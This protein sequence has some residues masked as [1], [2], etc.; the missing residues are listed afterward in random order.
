MT[1]TGPPE[2]ARES[3][4]EDGR[5]IAVT[6][7]VDI[8]SFA[9]VLSEVC[10]WVAFGKNGPHGLD[11]YRE[12][13]RTG[14]GRR[15]RGPDCF[16]LNDQILEAVEDE[17]T[18]IL[19]QQRCDVTTGGVLRLMPYMLHPEPKQRL[20]AVQ[21][22]RRLNDIVA[23]AQQHYASPSPS[24]PITPKSHA[25]ARPL[26]AEW[27]T[28]P[29]A[30]ILGH[31]RNR[32]PSKPG[33]TDGPEGSRSGENWA[34][35]PIVSTPQRM[36]S[37]IP[38]SD[39]YGHC[40][41][42]AEIANVLENRSI[43]SRDT[44]TM[45]R[46]ESKRR[47]TSDDEAPERHSSFAHRVASDGSA[48]YIGPQATPGRRKPNTSV[49]S[50]SRDALPGAS[51][52]RLS[53]TF[54][55]NSEEPA[56]VESPV[57]MSPVTGTI[58]QPAQKTTTQET[59]APPARINFASAERWRVKTKTEH[60]A[61]EPLPEIDCLDQLQGYDI[62][63]FVYIPNIRCT[64]DH[65]RYSSSTIQR[66]WARSGRLIIT[67]VATSPTSRIYLASCVTSPRPRM[68]MELICTTST[69]PPRGCGSA[70]SSL[71]Y[72]SRSPADRSEAP[73]LQQEPCET[74]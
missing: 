43:G 54:S 39:Q 65:C 51:S 52:A 36:T 56:Q 11:G 62:V 15:T 32:P 68:T 61:P 33:S 64:A 19:K 38:E 71:R 34:V 16:H 44:S 24:P 2:T 66:A 8:W 10:V 42:F 17:H 26:S 14:T 63:S 41:A 7:S 22:Q 31:R 30:S 49:S 40:P 1:W 4:L 18:K 70:K 74:S 72:S 9:A 73:P 67:R 29:R 60:H 59:F 58:A 12:R 57:P 3:K 69:N 5:K 20:T 55:I 50:S 23:E 6:T 25:E 27:P 21:L 13:R 37:A 45:T 47:A 28:S 48:Q 35:A 53:N 46:A